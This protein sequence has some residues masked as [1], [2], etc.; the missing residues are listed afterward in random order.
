MN[1]IINSITLLCC[2]FL[3][4]RTQAQKVDISISGGS[5]ANKSSIKLYGTYQ[6]E[7]QMLSPSFSFNVGI[8]ISTHLLP[9]V[10]FITGLYLNEKGYSYNERRYF[11]QSPYRLLLPYQSSHNLALNY[12][13]IPLLFSYRFTKHF[14]I[15]GGS[16]INLLISPFSPMYHSYKMDVPVQAGLSFISRRFS[17]DLLFAE[18]KM[19]FLTKYSE[20]QFKE[21]LH[22]EYYHRQVRLSIGYCINK[23][24]DGCRSCKQN[25]L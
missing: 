23:K 20:N 15:L 24:I 22:F 7:T 6:K 16:G 21:P 25:R 3:H 18:G 11:D 10:D 1:K 8:R 17:V 2:V 13:D 9:R 14:A 19:A 4:S 12:L 5:V